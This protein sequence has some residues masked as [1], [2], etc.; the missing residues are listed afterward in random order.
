M[1]GKPYCLLFTLVFLGGCTGTQVKE[2]AQFAAGAIILTAV[3]IAKSKDERDRER[4]RGYKPGETYCD[5]GCKLQQQAARD[6]QREATRQRK[7][8][9]EARRVQAEFDAFMEE[10]ETAEQ[11]AVRTTQS[12]VLREP[13]SDQ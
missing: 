4:R 13:D 5:G 10:L 1:L 6:R 12:V 2:S 3:E 8:R 9:Q 7:R 11:A